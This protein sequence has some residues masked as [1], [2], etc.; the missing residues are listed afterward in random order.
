MKKKLSNQELEL[1]ERFFDLEL[2]A[3][4]LAAFEKRMESDA[5]FHNE[6]RKYEKAYHLTAI[7]EKEPSTPN[8]DDMKPHALG[9]MKP[10]K[11]MLG[12]LAILAILTTGYWYANMNDNPADQPVFAEVEQYVDMLS[13]GV[14]RG[15]DNPDS[16]PTMTPIEK[17]INQMNDWQQAGTLDSES[18]TQLLMNEQDVDAREVIQWWI[19]RT[20]LESNDIE[21]AKNILNDIAKEPNYNS[22][23]K[24]KEILSDLE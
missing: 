19:V 7:L 6:V 16:E 15:S 4:E 13:S 14:V 8:F 20:Y 23:N 10:W 12:I 11:W 21:N 22:S 3:E 9:G 1:I 5:S 2:G 17:A 24:A 18:L